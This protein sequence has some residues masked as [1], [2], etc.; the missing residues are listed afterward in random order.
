MAAF[1]RCFFYCFK[2]GLP[3]LL[4]GIAVGLLITQFLIGGALPLSLKISIDSFSLLGAGLSTSAGAVLYTVAEMLPFKRRR[5][6]DLLCSLASK[7]TLFFAHWLT[8]LSQTLST[9]LV[10]LLYVWLRLALDGGYT[11]AHL[12]P[13]L[14]FFAGWGFILTVVT[15]FGFLVG[16]GLIDSLIL[17]SLWQLIGLFPLCIAANRRASGWMHFLPFF[18]IYDGSRVLTDRIILSHPDAATVSGYYKYKID[19]IERTDLLAPAFLAHLAAAAVLFALFFVFAK[20][21]SC[22]DAGAL[23]GHPAAYQFLIPYFGFALLFAF[24]GRLDV[25][26]PLFMGAGYLILRKGFKWKKL[27]LCCIAAAVIGL[28]F[29]R[30]TGLNSYV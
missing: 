5:D 20:R 26:A 2:S 19:L 14:A 22:G 28:I 6:S 23:S 7:R 18:S 10:C 1:K 16:N 27:D 17:A 12:L 29:L 30:I 21:L 3:A 25:A 15:A 13:A 11:A 24:S 4:V 8:A 9:T